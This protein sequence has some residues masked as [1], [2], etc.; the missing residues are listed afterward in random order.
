MAPKTR[1]HRVRP[2]R[3]R[4]IRC[5]CAGCGGARSGPAWSG[6]GRRRPC[7]PATCAWSSGLP[8]AELLQRRAEAAADGR[9][10]WAP[11][12]YA[13]PAGP[14]A[15]RRPP[16]GG[17]SGPRSTG[18]HGPGT[19]APGP[20]AWPPPRRRR[21]PG[22]SSARRP[23]R[24]APRPPVARRAP[25]RAPAPCEAPAR[26]RGT[27]RRQ[28]RR[29]TPDPSRPVRPAASPGDRAERWQHPGR[30]PAARAARPRTA[31][32]RPGPRPRRRHAI[33]R[34]RR[35]P[36][37]PGR[38]SSRR[39]RPAR[40]A[41]PVSSLVTAAA[42]DQRHRHRVAPRRL[43]R[44][45]RCPS[46]GPRPGRPVPWA[47]AA[48]PGRRPSRPAGGRRTG[49]AG[50]PARTARW[51]APAGVPA[52]LPLAPAA[53]AR[54]Q[55]PERRTGRA[56]A[57]LRHRY[58]PRA[59]AGPVPAAS[60]V[61]GQP[62]PSS[63]DRG[64]AGRHALVLAPVEVDRIADK[65][66]RRLLRRLAIERER[67]GCGEH[68]QG[69]ARLGAARPRTG[70]GKLE[71]LT[72]ERDGRRPGRGAVQPERDQHLRGRVVGAAA[73]RQLGGAAAATGD[74]RVPLRRGGDALDRAVLR[75]LRVPQ[76]RWAS[77][78]P[79]PRSCRP[80]SPERQATDVR[81]HT[82]QV[83]ALAEVDREL[84]R[85]P[86]CQLRWGAFDIFTG[87]LTSLDQRFTLFLEDGTPVR[88]TLSCS[89]LESAPAGQR[90]GRASC[91]PPTSPRPARCGATTPCRASP[92]RSTTIPRLWR[93]IATANG[94]VNPRHLRRARC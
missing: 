93:H 41:R 91:T 69:P 5:C 75:H 37:P 16:G 71:R 81:R 80:C 6:P 53:G 17:R 8:L 14:S 88:A 27:G 68:Q 54:G 76:R 70:G 83:A 19:A 57:R 43:A 51:A 72:I 89:F 86:I 47:P 84:H 18:R 42:T 4:W 73:A 63:A 39:G 55:R 64:R 90:P 26:R 82:E 35:R 50:Q 30:P 48:Q 94:I 78:T 15:D 45:P 23:A 12:V 25:S 62:R 34:A 65:V 2:G 7:S 22:R 11:I 67:G 58:P 20:I 46:S 74:V 36:H 77:R 60:T 49:H 40:R 31:S 28:P 59:A 79:S 10:A 52:S 92:P 87:V 61:A 85:P 38:W 44:P 3:T 66:Q 29:R 1:R 33:G 13:R 21:R 24:T 9:A 56:T 32:G